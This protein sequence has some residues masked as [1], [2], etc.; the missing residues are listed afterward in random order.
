MSEISVS[1]ERRIFSTKR[2]RALASL[3][4][5]ASMTGL[6][7]TTTVI[8]AAP[9]HAESVRHIAGTNG[10]GL[11]LRN[12]P[13]TNSAK[14][15]TI[16]EG[17]EFDAQCWVDGENVA[18]NTK[19]EQGTD[20][21]TGQ[22]GYVSDLYLDTGN[23][24]DSNQLTSEGIPECKSD[25]PPKPEILDRYNRQAAANYAEEHAEDIPPSSTSCTQFVSRALWAAGVR[26]S[27]DWNDGEWQGQHFEVSGLPG[28]TAAW[29][30]S[31]LPEY[32]LQTFPKSYKRELDFSK[33]S[34][35]DAEPGD[36]IA[37]DWGDDGEIDHLSLV[38]DETANSYP[39]V[40]EW[41]ADGDNPT[42]YGKR[43]WTYSELNHMWIQSEPALKNVRAYLI[44]IDT[45][46]EHAPDNVNPIG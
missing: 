44:H 18:G 27:Y 10:L 22:E 30:A 40:A 36:I 3:A 19:W 9:A 5:V 8:N 34:V 37:Y 33:N 23:Y 32:I 45:S 14:L 13:S 42:P 25:S 21:A 2:R 6:A 11:A 12:S 29:R 39:E 31:A 15:T 38:V 20:V 4:V 16:S 17:A 35:Q 43:G 7:S 28:T 26:K 46:F 24:P 41:S 1:K